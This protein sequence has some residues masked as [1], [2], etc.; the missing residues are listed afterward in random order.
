MD[1]KHWHL[2]RRVLLRYPLSGLLGKWKQ[3]CHFRRAG[4]LINIQSMNI[5]VKYD[6]DII[7]RRRP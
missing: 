2:R 1:I 3:S 4:Y 7:D 5:I 6:A